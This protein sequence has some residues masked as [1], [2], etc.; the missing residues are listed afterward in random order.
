[1]ELLHAFM[2]ALPV[3]L[4]VGGH[5]KPSQRVQ[6]VN[7]DVLCF[8]NPAAKLERTR[9]DAPLHFTRSAEKSYTPQTPCA[10]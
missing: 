5:L 6:S 8:K 4:R 2:D 1:M 10:R 3:L 9:L 7:Q